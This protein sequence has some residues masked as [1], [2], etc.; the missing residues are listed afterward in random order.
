MANKYT[1]LELDKEIRSISGYYS[2][3]KEV[4]LKQNGREVLYVVGRATIEAAC[5]GCGTW[6]YAIVP[7]YV[8]KWQGEQN[9]DG[10]PTTDVEPVLD[11]SVQ[12][13]VSQI[14]K[15]KEGVSQV[16]FW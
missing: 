1:H 14:I 9:K 3:L 2:P 13:E 10:L 8:M 15:E 4:R 11:K 7:G 16:E 5:C 12:K 6:M